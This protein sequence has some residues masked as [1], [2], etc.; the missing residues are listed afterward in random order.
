MGL[1]GRLAACELYNW[2]SQERV[3][4]KFYSE[5]L[6]T[7]APGKKESPQELMVAVGPQSQYQGQVPGVA[8]YS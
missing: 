4:L 2:N 6:E 1:R 3:L 5:L 8:P 7:S